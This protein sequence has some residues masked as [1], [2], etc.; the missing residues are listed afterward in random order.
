MDLWVIF[1]HGDD[2]VLRRWAVRP[3]GTVGAD[4]EISRSSD[5]QQLRRELPPG[6]RRADSRILGVERAIEAW[7]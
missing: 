5:L 1:K 6:V 7:N 2:F 3:E 4:L